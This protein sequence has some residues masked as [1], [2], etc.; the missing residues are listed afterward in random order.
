[1]NRENYETLRDQI[2][3]DIQRILANFSKVPQTRDNGII[4]STLP[5]IFS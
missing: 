4:Y 5:T 3:D 2:S 1:M